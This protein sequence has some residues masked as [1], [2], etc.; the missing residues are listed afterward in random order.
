[1]RERRMGGGGGARGGIPSIDD[2]EKKNQPF[3]FFVFFWVKNK[4]VDYNPS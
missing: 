1:V 2:L 4:Q 3:L